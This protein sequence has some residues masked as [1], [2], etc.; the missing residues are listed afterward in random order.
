MYCHLLRRIDDK[1]RKLNETLDCGESQK[2]CNWNY[3]I[4]R[5]RAMPPP[6]SPNIIV[7]LCECMFISDV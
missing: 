1:I 2:V 3:A 7:L 6:Q 5:N 4:H